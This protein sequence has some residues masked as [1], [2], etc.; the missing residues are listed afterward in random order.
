MPRARRPARIAAAI[1]ACA[2]AA[3]LAACGGGSAS[4][5]APAVPR[6]AAHLPAAPAGTAALTGVVKFTGTAPSPAK[7]QMSADP[8]CAEKHPGGAFSEEVL[9]NPDGTLKNVMVYVKEGP[10]G[11]KTAPPGTPAV[12]D[13]HDCLYHPRV[14]GMQAGQPLEI[15]NSDGTLHNVHSFAQSNQNFNAGMVKG[16]KPIT[17]GFDAPEVMVRMKC[18]VHPWMV[19]Y[20]GVFDHPFFSV[21]GD[22]GRFSMKGLPAGDYVVAAWH[23]KFGTKEAKVTVADGAAAALDFSF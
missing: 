13:Q 23:E 2:A 7:I 3:A 19:G 21:T 17:R 1:L 22:D 20:I 14:L 5:P 6:T 9:V 15:R 4:G 11:L 16:A 12:F 10:P 18:D 8:A